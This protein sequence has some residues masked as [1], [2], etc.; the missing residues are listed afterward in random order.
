MKTTIA[1]IAIAMGLFTAASVQAAPTLSAS[2]VPTFS[3]ATPAKAKVR[4]A[5]KAKKAVK[6]RKTKNAAF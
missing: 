2:G 1:T 6:P 4:P 3:A 5:K